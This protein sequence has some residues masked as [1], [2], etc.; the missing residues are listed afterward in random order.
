MAPHTP[1]VWLA[2]Q[3]LFPCVTSGLA[4]TAS[5][6]AAFGPELAAA[7]A[8]GTAAAAPLGLSAERV[9]ATIRS[10]ARGSAPG[11]SGLRIE[12][13]C[14]LAKDGRNAL[15]GVVRLLSTDA[16]TTVVPTVASHALVGAELLLL[17]KPGASAV[18]GVPRLRPIGMPETIRKLAVGSLARDLRASAA[19]LMAPLKLGIG[20]PNACERLFHALEAQLE[21]APE[22]GV[23]L[24]DFKNA[25]NLI[26]RAAARAF[27]DRAIPSLTPHVAAKYGGAPPAVYGW[28]AARRGGDSGA[29]GDGCN[30]REGTDDGEDG[31]G[32]RRG[33]PRPSRRWR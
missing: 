6:E 18:D 23:L 14:A 19:A 13:L 20:V 3:Q 7:A 9:V 26:S 22:E 12:H 25:F 28:A 8:H 29:D 11:P 30:G 17:F 24:L 27:V 31:G 32:G 33:P 2:A 15:V 1:A 10:A 16:A 4:T 5:V 21:V